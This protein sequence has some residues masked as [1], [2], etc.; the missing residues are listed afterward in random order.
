MVSV[1][2]RK[3]L[4]ASRSVPYGEVA[5][6]AVSFATATKAA[7]ALGV[8]DKLKEDVTISLPARSSKSF[9]EVV[10]FRKDGTALE[11]WKTPEILRLHPRDVHLFTNDS[12]MSRRAMVAPRGDAILFRTEIVRAIIYQDKTILFPCRR[13][14]ETLHVAQS[15]KSAITQTSP[16]PFEFKVLE[17]LLAETSCFFE[18]GCKRIT[19]VAN[20]VVED[21]NQNFEETS[22][23]LQ[24][25]VPITGKLHELQTDIHETVEAISNVIDDDDELR[26][27]CLTDRAS[28]FERNRNVDD[29]DKKCDKVDDHGVG[30]VARESEPGRMGRPKLPNSHAFS[31]TVHMRMASRILESYEY[32]MLNTQSALKELSE[33][34]DQSRIVWTMQLGSRRLRVLRFNVFVSVASLCGLVSSLPAAYLGMNL[35]SGLEEHEMLLWPVAYSSVGVGMLTGA[36]L[37]SLYRLNPRKSYSARL[38]DMRS[39]RDLLFYHLDDLDAIIDAFKV[40]KGEMTRQKF[41]LVVREALQGKKISGEEISLLFRVLK[42]NKEAVLEMTEMIKEETTDLSHHFT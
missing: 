32:N 7:Y 12:S 20:T 24:R 19:M 17:S 35:H 39:L 14:S 27:L 22:S 34:M 30:S 18:K 6:V 15:I 37:Y 21:I 13:M 8:V 41:E 42:R 25:L 28:M 31:Q 38:G 1:I 16:L 29:K 2:A 40:H 33:V 26:A 10:E 23:E 11:T 36:V 4:L 9:W 3:G 5:K